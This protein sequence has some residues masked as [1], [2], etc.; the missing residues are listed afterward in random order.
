MKRASVGANWT[1]C[2]SGSSDAEPCSP[3]VGVPVTRRTAAVALT[4]LV[5]IAAVAGCTSSSGGD[6]SRS[7]S[8]TKS[9]TSTAA[10]SSPVSSPGTSSSAPSTA[11]PA[12]PRSKAALAAYNAFVSASD[13]AERDPSRIS[14]LLPRYAIDPALGTEQGLLTQ[15]QVNNIQWRGTPPTSRARVVKTGFAATPYP[16]VTVV[17]CPTVSSSWRPYDT[18]TGKPL[19]LVKPK[20]APPWA[21]TAT[22]ALYKGKWVVQTTKTDMT[23]TCKP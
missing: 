21:T 12:D 19:P 1:H 9:V 13:T 23:R 15:F 16:N 11:P 5:V 18:K 3:V 8:T 7:P 14:K 22:V 4:L 20:V 17:D 10:T 2:D 6:P